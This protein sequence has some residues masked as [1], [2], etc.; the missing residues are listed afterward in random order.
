MSYRLLLSAL[1]HICMV[2]L[3][4]RIK[5]SRQ[6]HAKRH[7]AKANLYF[8]VPGGF[9]ICLSY[10]ILFTQPVVLI[11]KKYKYFLVILV[12]NKSSGVK[13]TIPLSFNKIRILNL[14]Q[15]HKH[16]ALQH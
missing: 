11:E 14:L 4:S 12:F 10:R 15:A 2:N 3:H 13:V 1:C 9:V 16:N 6:N 5:K 7:S 8:D